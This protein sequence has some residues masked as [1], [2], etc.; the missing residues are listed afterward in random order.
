MVKSTIGKR[1]NFAAE[2]LRGTVEDEVFL[3]EEYEARTS[4][5]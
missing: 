1:V 2:K 5:T 4:S 3:L